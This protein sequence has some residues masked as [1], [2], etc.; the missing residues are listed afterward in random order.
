MRYS[1][2]M[3]EATT[4]GVRIRVEST[5]EPERSA[6]ASG[7]Y[8][9]S[10]RVRIENVGSEVVQLVSRHWVITDADGRVEHV[11]GPGVV[12]EQPVLRPG[13]TFEYTSFCPLPTPN[14]T[15]HGEYQ[16]RTATGET[17]DAAIPPFG[18]AIPHSVN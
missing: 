13:Q 8:F 18:L 6:P 3:S 16:M 10:Y 4:R 1:R 17:F 14:G 9:F 11:R 15:M 7:E 12:G 5:F 2:A